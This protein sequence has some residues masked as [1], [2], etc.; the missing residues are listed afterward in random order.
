MKE[1]NSRFRV[2]ETQKTFAAKFSQ[3]VQRA[4]ETTEEY[5]ADLKR[6]YAKAYQFRDLKTRQEDLVRK[7]LGVVGWCDGAGL[8]SN[9]GASY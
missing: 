4:D 2:V 8:T 9:A 7:F 3:R 6:L 5:A 1:L